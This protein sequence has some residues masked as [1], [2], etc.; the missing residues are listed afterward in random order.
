[1]LTGALRCAMTAAGFSVFLAGVAEAKPPI[2]TKYSYYSIAGNS[3]PEIYRAMVQR[4]PRVEGVKAYATTTAVSSQSGRL[5]QG[6]NCSLE[7]YSVNIDFT[8]KLPRLKNETALRGPAQS[9]WRSFS[10]FLK[11]HEE[12]HRAIWMGCRTEMQSKVASLQVKSCSDLNAQTARLWQ[13]VSQ[14]CSKK[15]E[16][17]DANDQAKLLRHPFVKTVM[18]GSTPTPQAVAIPDKKR[19]A[20]A[21]PTKKKKKRA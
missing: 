17:L 9:Q 6:Q 19:Q 16:R 5:L 2:S 12:Q 3:A 7:G 4:G 10:A 15:H 11:A 20:M 8:I 14:A 21:V 18:A 13:Q 1:M